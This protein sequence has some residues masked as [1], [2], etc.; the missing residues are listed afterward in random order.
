VTGSDLDLEGE[1]RRGTRRAAATVV[2]PDGLW[3]AVEHGIRRRARS[4]RLVRVAV[5][6]VL[7]VILG[8]SLVLVRGGDGASRET[9]EPLPPA[10]GDEWP[11][12]PEAPIAPRLQNDAVWTG[13]EMVVYGGVR[14]DGAPADD[15]AAYDPATGEWREVASP[16]DE[17]R[18]TPIS[19]WT[20]H[21]VVAFGGVD[22][23]TRRSTTGAVYDPAEDTWR[24]IATAGSGGLSSSGSYA[25]WTGEQVLV[26]GFF[27]PTPGL[28]TFHGTEGAALYDP[29]ADR[30]TSLPD[31][32]ELLP[33]FGDAFWTGTE[34]IV[35]G[36]EQGSGQAAP[37]GF[38]ALAF[39]PAASTWRT[40]PA[41]PIGP[42]PDLLVAWT[43]RELVLGGGGSYGSPASGVPTHSDA[44]ALD[45][46]AGT[47]RALPDAPVPFGGSR[48]Y[49]D[50]LVDQ[51]VVALTT[52]DRA[53]RSLLFDTLTDTWAFGPVGWAPA[54]Q[55]PDVPIVSTGDRLL[56]WG[57][58]RTTTPSAR[59]TAAPRST[60]PP[61]H[62]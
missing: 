19:V 48:R 60:P 44:V 10:A 5:A 31:P 23:G 17:V 16:P 61:A 3:P 62:P 12:L 45:P 24:P 28:D 36:A 42:R 39:D 9:G 46:A 59:P 37:E 20:G 49:R 21:E 54:G 41:P 18:G 22:D 27:R 8:T 14:P 15:A 30:W 32:P 53:G 29:A 40:L 56:L 51:Q 38:V 7:V 50:V 55:Q 11:V 52:T 47:W 34:M 43:G 1:L 4:R 25:V 57:A 33:T 26:A 58:P 6:A 2:V 13:H 35:V